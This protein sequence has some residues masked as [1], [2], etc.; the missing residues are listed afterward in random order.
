MLIPGPGEYWVQGITEAA[1]RRMAEV[2]RERCVPTYGFAHVRLVRVG[3]LPEGVVGG[4][5]GEGD[6]DDDH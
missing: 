1:Y 5:D 3:P 2:D 6:Q 4:G